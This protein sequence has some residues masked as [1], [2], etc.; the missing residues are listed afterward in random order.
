MFYIDIYLGVPVIPFSVSASLDLPEKPGSVSWPSSRHPRR[1]VVSPAFHSS[2]GGE[3]VVGF[4]SEF[5]G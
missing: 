1:A 5:D 4:G 3:L 2:D